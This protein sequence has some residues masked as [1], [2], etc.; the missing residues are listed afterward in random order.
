M[1][2][3]CPVENTLGLAAY[4]RRLL[5]CDETAATSA[6]ARQQ[7]PGISFESRAAVTFIG[8]LNL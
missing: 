7:R 4:W 8:M 3:K 6:P 2:A 1:V 5:A